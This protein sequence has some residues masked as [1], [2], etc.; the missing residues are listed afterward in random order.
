MTITALPAAPS[1]D[2]PENFAAEADAFVAALANLVTELNTV[3]GT[4]IPAGSAGAGSLTGNT[5]AAGVTASSLTSLGTL[6]SLTVNK[7]SAGDNATFGQTVKGYFSEN[8]SVMG[9]TTAAALAGS[10]FSANAALVNLLVAGTAVLIATGSALSSILNSVQFGSA[11]ATPAGGSA[12][13]FMA[14]G[15]TV[16][17]GIYIGSGAPTLSAPQG[18]LYLRSNGS[19]TND[20]AY[21]N[22]NGTTG[23]TALTT[24]A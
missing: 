12:A 5:L 16:G 9:W 11:T 8:G 15:S 14:L 21:I 23:W 17:F 1:I 6:T 24:A 20:R 3:I 7:G 13:L 2:D 4:S 18:S 22:T 19:T 10:G